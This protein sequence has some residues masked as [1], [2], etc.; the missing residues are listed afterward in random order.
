MVSLTWP[1]LN[2]CVCVWGRV[3]LYF[4]RDFGDSFEFSVFN[5][6]VSSLNTYG[7]TGNEMILLIHFSF[8]FISHFL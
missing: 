1:F 8:H 7:V 3:Y 4:Q 2:V 5:I 6:H